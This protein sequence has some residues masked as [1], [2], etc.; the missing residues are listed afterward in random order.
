MLRAIPFEILRGQNGKFC[1]PPSPTFFF[2]DP[3]HHI[4]FADPQHFFPIP[5]PQ[6]LKING[7]ALSVSSPLPFV[8]RSTLVKRR[9]LISKILFSWDALVILQMVWQQHLKNLFLQHGSMC[10]TA[11]LRFTGELI[12]VRHLR[13]FMQWNLMGIN[14]YKQPL[15]MAD[16]RHIWGAFR[17]Y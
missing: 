16:F 6:D 2:A 3:F 5:S 10:C 4:F 13:N 7:I 8:Q 12:I 9:R 1:R 11:S 15:T 14:N 17:H